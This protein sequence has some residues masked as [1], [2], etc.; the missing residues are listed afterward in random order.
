MEWRIIND[1]FYHEL[2]SRHYIDVSVVVDKLIEFLP[3]VE[4][5]SHGEIIKIRDYVLNDED[6]TIFKHLPNEVIDAIYF[7]E[8]ECYDEEVAEMDYEI[9][10]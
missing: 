7:L 3:P 10:Y 9:E 8:L 4:I 1:G 2:V 6:K 5:Y